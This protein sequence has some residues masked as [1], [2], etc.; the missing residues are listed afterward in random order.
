MY[1]YIYICFQDTIANECAPEPVDEK[2][3][4]G[5]LMKK[6]MSKVAPDRRRIRK[7]AA[8]ALAPKGS[9]YFYGTN[10]DNQEVSVRPRSDHSKCIMIFLG[11][12]MVCMM[13][14]SYGKEGESIMVSIAEKLL[15]KE[16]T[17]GELYALRNTMMQ[18]KGL[19]V[20]AKGKG[21]GKA[22]V[23]KIAKAEEE[24]TTPATTPA[25]KKARAEET[26]TTGLD[27]RLPDDFGNVYGAAA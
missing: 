4:E 27:W 26:K 15:S 9:W 10:Q 17:M 24:Q 19:E 14:A 13:A 22:G 12:R 25:T 21:K 2:G 16:T 7:K 18:E 6:P 11:N 3:P 1:I 5:E 8:G 23:K 20:P